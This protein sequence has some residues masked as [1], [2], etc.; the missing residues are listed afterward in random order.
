MYKIIMQNKWVLKR[1]LRIW[2]YIDY[3]SMHFR[4]LV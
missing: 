2:F 1:D 4:F 3:C